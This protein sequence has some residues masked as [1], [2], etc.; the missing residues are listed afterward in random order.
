M[1][2]ATW[3]GDKY[4]MA[5]NVINHLITCFVIINRLKINQC[6]IAQPWAEQQSTV[7]V[8]DRDKDETKVQVYLFIRMTMTQTFN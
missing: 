7:L 1:T 3:P 8:R 2:Y 5:A 6:W 4:K